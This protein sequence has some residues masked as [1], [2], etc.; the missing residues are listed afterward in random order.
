MPGRSGGWNRKTTAIRDSAG[1]IQYRDLC[2]CGRNKSLVAS[3]CHFCYTK[4][5]HNNIP[6]YTCQSCGT[7]FRDADRQRRCRL[8][9]D[10]TC[11]VFCSLQCYLLKNPLLR[12]RKTYPCEMCGV[13]FVR[14]RHDRDDCRFCSKHCYGMARKLGLSTFQGIPLAE[15]ARLVGWWAD[16][17]RVRKLLGMPRYM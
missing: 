12:H 10:P 13:A 3:R 5:R 9:R 6:V 8:K 16:I 17:Y 7:Q 2:A 15:R 11:R 4:S 14:K 1:R